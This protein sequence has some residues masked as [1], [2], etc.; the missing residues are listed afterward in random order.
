[1]KA[2]KKTLYFIAEM[3]DAILEG[4]YHGLTHGPSNPAP[5][6]FPWIRPFKALYVKVFGLPPYLEQ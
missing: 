4:A 1:M 5:I 3:L 6:N 2:I